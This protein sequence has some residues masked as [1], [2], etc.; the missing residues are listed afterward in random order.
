M[1]IS[2]SAQ[3]VRNDSFGQASRPLHGYPSPKV[4]PN[5]MSRWYVGLRDVEKR[6]C[7]RRPLR[8]PLLLIDELMDSEDGHVQEIPAECMN[9]S[10]SGLFGVVPIGYG[11]AAHQRYTFKLT[12]GECGPEPGQHQIVTQPG[13]ILRAELLLGDSGEVDRIGIAVRLYG[14]R[15]GMVPMPYRL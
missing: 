14:H 7:A 10:D 8:C 3:S 4:G 2:S 9:I 1:S 5:F 12:I 6:Q 13:H 15:H 11:V